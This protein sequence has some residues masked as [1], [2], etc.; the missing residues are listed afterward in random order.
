MP[1]GRRAGR[2]GSHSRSS[3]RSRVAGSHFSNS[4]HN[5]PTKFNSAIRFNALY[6]APRIH[7]SGGRKY[8]YSTTTLRASASLT[9]F[10]FIALFIAIISISNLVINVNAM[11][12]II[13][14]R[15]YYINMIEFAEKNP[16]FMRDAIV[17]DYEQSLTSDAYYIIY[18]IDGRVEGYSYSVYTEEEARALLSQTIKVAVNSFILSD[19][20][21]SIPVDYKNKSI[22]SDGEYVVARSNKKIFLVM[23]AL[24][25]SI[26]VILI[27]IT[28]II[29]VKG[30]QYIDGQEANSTIENSSLSKKTVIIK[31]EYCGTILNEAQ[32]SCPNC[33]ANRNT[34]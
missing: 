20:T 17:T 25:L 9:V 23:T 19:E 8:T 34:K 26:F 32:S 6:S 7:I 18:M 31:F 3:S 13:Y 14:D 21:D 16:T 12:T 24:S 4:S 10:I 29:Q 1:S 27:V 22:E 2:S 5:R 11:N 33:G 30:K 15:H 28:V